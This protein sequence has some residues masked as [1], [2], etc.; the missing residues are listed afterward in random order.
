MRIRSSTAWGA[1]RRP[2]GRST[3]EGILPTYRPTSARWEGL[4]HPRTWFR[5]PRCVE[6]P[7]KQ[8]KCLRD[9]CTFADPT[10]SYARQSASQ[11]SS[12]STGAKGRDEVVGKARSSEKSSSLNTMITSSPIN[13]AHKL[14]TTMGVYG[15]PNVQGIPI[16]RLF[17]VVNDE[18]QA[19]PSDLDCDIN[20][21]HTGRGDVLGVLQLWIGQ[22]DRT[23]N[24]T[25][26]F[27]PFLVDSWA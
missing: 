1:S 3:W 10:R 20:R 9:W 16:G 4:M 11:S 22:W 2:A 21:L 15:L 18:K 19:F 25:V 26:V 13:L 24:G 27:P 23:L 8:L 6:A 17:H 5:P 7:D 12:S 14:G